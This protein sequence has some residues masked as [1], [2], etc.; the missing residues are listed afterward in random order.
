MPD[1][2][3]QLHLFRHDTVQRVAR[4][5]GSTGTEPRLVMLTCNNVLSAFDLFTSI[6]TADAQDLHFLNVPFQQ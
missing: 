3:R 5:C 6:D 4:Q 2:P 1:I